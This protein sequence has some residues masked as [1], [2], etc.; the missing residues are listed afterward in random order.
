MK[1][2][3]S[4]VL[5]LGVLCVAPHAAS[6]RKL[7]PG[8]ASLWAG[9]HGNETQLVGP[10]TGFGSEFHGSELGLHL[11]FSR[12]MCEDWTAVISGGFDVGSSQFR[13]TAG[14][15]VRYSSNSWNFRI[16][17]D[18]YAYINEQVALYAG[19]GIV[20][21]RGNA[22]VDGT[23]DPDFDSKW[24]TVRTVGLN[25]RIGMKAHFAPHYALFGHIG[26]VIAS[27]AAKN[28]DGRNTWWTNHNEGSVGLAVDL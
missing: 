28:G 15:T 1:A 20:Y 26:Q 22:E 16:G 19:P 13:P 10:S 23:G 4:M 2:A 8:S 21:W 17:L 14:P 18:R 6:A 9:L 25:G 12:A 3:I 7:V 27:N 24:P 11:A 5:V